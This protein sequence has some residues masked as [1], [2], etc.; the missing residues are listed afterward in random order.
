M[1]KNLKNNLKNIEI[2]WEDKNN[3]PYIF[4]LK[5]SNFF[6]VSSDSTSMISEC[7]ITE[8]PIYVFTYHLKEK[9]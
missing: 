1:K 8:K 4:A 5:Y 6:I 7:A 9:V 3:N 2:I